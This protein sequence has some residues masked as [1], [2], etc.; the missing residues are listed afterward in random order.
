[1][2]KAIELACFSEKRTLANPIALGIQ[3]NAALS[4]LTKAYKGAYFEISFNEYFSGIYDS[5]WIFIYPFRSF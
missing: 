2:P 3:L 1:M 5:W 4:V